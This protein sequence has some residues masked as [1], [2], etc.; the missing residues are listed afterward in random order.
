MQL[1]LS[2]EGAGAGVD[3]EVPDIVVP[4]LP[5]TQTS[6]GTPTLF[7]PDAAQCGS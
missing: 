4:D 3:S 2:V 5:S 1:R 6:L 7:R